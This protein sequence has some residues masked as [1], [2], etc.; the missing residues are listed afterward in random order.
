MMYVCK[1]F[2]SAS[3]IDNKAPI[4]IYTWPWILN[5]DATLRQSSLCTIFV[6]PNDVIHKQEVNF[7]I[8]RKNNFDWNVVPANNVIN[9]SCGKFIGASEPF[10]DDQQRPDVSPL[11]LNA[12]QCWYSIYIT[13]GYGLFVHSIYVD[14]Y[15]LLHE[16]V[17]IFTCALKSNKNC[18]RICAKYTFKT[19]FL[20]AYYF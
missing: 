15:F 6:A 1:H 17:A 20:Q 2:G 11:Y 12:W 9:G 5:V 14:Q 13:D 7:W 4:W 8:L 19:F 16:H 18:M 10:P 3:G